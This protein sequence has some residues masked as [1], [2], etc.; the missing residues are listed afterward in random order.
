MNNIPKS[1]NCPSRRGKITKEDFA[2]WNGAA[3]FDSPMDYAGNGGSYICGSDQL[4]GGDCTS[5]NGP[6]VAT[7]HAQTT[8]NGQ[9][10]L[11]PTVT[12]GTALKLTDI[13]DGLSNT[14]LFGEKAADSRTTLTKNED[15]SDIP[16]LTWGDDQGFQ[17]GY[18]WDS[19]RFGE[20]ATSNT[21]TNP[22]TGFASIPYA[23]AWGFPDNPVQD[24]PCPQEGNPN[25]EC[26]DPVFHAQ[27]PNM[28]WGS[29][30]PGAFNVALA[31]GSVRNISYSID[32]GVLS[33][34][35]AR[36]DGQ[37]FTLDQ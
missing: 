35:C 34:L 25:S 12:S 29:A 27:W 6:I 2:T 22:K 19:I 28:R 31:D 1:F 10:V 3:Y 16:D 24:Q 13:T 23:D 15:W 33:L 9:T 26:P 32:L 36:N 21:T 18:S 20:G 30:H 37:V 14:M 8:I 17:N 4:G 7:N 11:L 5:C